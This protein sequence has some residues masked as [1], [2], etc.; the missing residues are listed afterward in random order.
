MTVLQSYDV[1]RKNQYVKMTISPETL[2][3]LADGVIYLHGLG[4]DIDNNLAYGV[5]WSDEKYIRELPPYINA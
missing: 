4:F 1:N 3:M 5:N 2:K